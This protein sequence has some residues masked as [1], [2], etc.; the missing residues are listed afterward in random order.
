MDIGTNPYMSVQERN[1]AIEEYITIREAGE[2]LGIA[3]LMHNH[4]GN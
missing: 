3:G 4:Q 1:V 2:S